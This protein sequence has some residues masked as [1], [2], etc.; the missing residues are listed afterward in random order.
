M[1]SQDLPFQNHLFSVYD[2]YKKDNRFNTYGFSGSS[3]AKSLSLRLLHTG[4]S[5][6]HL[7]KRVTKVIYFLFRIK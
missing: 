2:C 4:Q 7:P 1:A 6:Q 3:V 5:I